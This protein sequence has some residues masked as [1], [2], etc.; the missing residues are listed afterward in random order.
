M[1]IKRIFK[2]DFFLYLIF[3]WSII[4]LFS[5]SCNEEKSTK[6]GNVKD[7]PVE[8]ENSV[9]RLIKSE[10]FYTVFISDLDSI[11]KICSYIEFPLNGERFTLYGLDDE[12]SSLNEKKL[13]SAG[14]F[15]IVV[16]DIF[17]EKVVE[18]LKKF[19]LTDAVFAINENGVETS[20]TVSLNKQPKDG[21]VM[22][23]WWVNIIFERVKNSF[24]ITSIQYDGNE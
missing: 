6:V 24:K 11:E 2:S 22:Q 10:E 18:A 23:V 8:A 20:F 13:I 21:E 15:K 1:K 19:N 14:D 3:L 4:I 17:N 5:A 7:E 16:N 9:E 12:K